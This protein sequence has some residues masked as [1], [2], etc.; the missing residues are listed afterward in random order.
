[1]VFIPAGSF[2]LGSGGGEEYSFYEGGNS[3]NPFLISN[4]AEIQVR[5]N[6]SSLYY[7][8]L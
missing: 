3:P 6:L 8:I 5:N 2:Y 7:I 4:N 1:M